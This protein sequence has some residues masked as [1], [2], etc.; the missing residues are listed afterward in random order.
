METEKKDDISLPQ[1]LEVEEI[2]EFYKDLD[3]DAEPEDV[4]VIKNKPKL[5]QFLSLF[6]KK[7][8]EET[9]I[10]SEIYGL[11]EKGRLILYRSLSAL[12]SVCIIALS[13]TLAYFMPGNEEII[14]EQQ[15]T[16]RQDKDYESLKSRHDTLKT[17]I[18]NLTE[19][20]KDKKE[21]IDKISD[22]DNTKAEL[23]TQITAKAYELNELNAQ[24]EEK[25]KAVAQL[26]ASI[27]EKT[28]PETVLPPGKYIAGKNI[29]AGKYRV[30]GTGKFM[31]ASA[32]GKSKINT[33]LGST[34]IEV[35]LETN[36]V[37]KFDS[38]VKFTSFN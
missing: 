25:R 27:A 11:S 3:T 29:A 19:S 37:I 1:S 26:D 30:M 7:K 36:D 12:I 38:K 8:S 34:P 5:K 32:A 10:Q 31:V 22:F 4:E 35:T 2:I 16:L 18:E 13:F 15:K 24:I 14:K 17:D 20:N 9:D 21:Q 28:P 6:I 23:R 33:T